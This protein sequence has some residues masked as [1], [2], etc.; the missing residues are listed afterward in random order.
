MKNNTN[1]VVWGIGQHAE[2]NILPALKKIKGMNIYGILSR[3]KKNVENL[4]KQYNCITWQNSSE[5][6]KDKNVKVVFISVPSHKHYECGLKVLKANKHF[7]SEKPFTLCFSESNHL[8]KISKQKG[9]SIA[10]GLMYIHHPHFTEIRKYFK[11]SNVKI[12]NSRFCFPL[13]KD[14]FEKYISKKEYSNDSAYLDI[15]IY[16]TSL[17]HE[18]CNH[19]IKKIKILYNKFY[20]FSNN[21]AKLSGSSLL[22][23]NNILFSLFWGL[24][25]AYKNEIEIVTNK[26]TI[27]SNK[28]FAKPDDYKPKVIKIDSIGNE[29]QISLEK[30]NHFVNMFQK[31]QELLTSSVKAEKERIRIL[32]LAKL[33]EKIRDT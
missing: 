16:P 18:L 29:R 22:S 15:G 20:F 19:E 1:I 7:W 6:L 17:V 24:D 32:S 14:L 13:R 12:I 28:I 3:N 9:L 4:K 2:K 5:M 31:F 23:Y 30:S 10:E 27:Y 26:E 33:N 11:K 25:Y 8:A 21:S